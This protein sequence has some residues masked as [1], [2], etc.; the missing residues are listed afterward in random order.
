MTKHF[1]FILF[2]VFLSSGI[3][4]QS[5]FYDSKYYD[6]DILYEAGA[7]VGFMNGLTDVG[8]RKGSPLSPGYYDF[9]SLKLNYS[10]YVSILYKGVVEGRIEFTKGAIAGNDANSNAQN[11]R[12]RNLNYKSKMTELSLTAAVHPLILMNNETL[13]L[14]SPYVMAGVAAFTFNPQTLYKGEWIDLRSMNTEGQSTTRYPAREP[15]KSLAVALPVG[16]GVKYEWNAKFNV[17][18]EGLFRFTNT[19]YIDDAS[20]TYPDL[21]VFSTDLQKSLS[22]RY[23]ELK[24]QLNYTN[25]ERGNANNNDSFFSVNLKV[26]YVIGREKIP[27]NYNPTK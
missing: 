18:L 5:Y 16:F 27:I 20:T 23:K 15:Y 17:R 25:A 11:V 22:H 3:F 6:A 2:F 26:G 8:G 4:A 19:D 13:P 1:S 9:K 24:P 10:G 14:F 21:S 7:S 12:T